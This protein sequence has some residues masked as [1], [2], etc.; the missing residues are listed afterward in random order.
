MLAGFPIISEIMASNDVTLM[1]EDGDS[2]DWIE[3]FNASDQPVDLDNWHL[4]DDVDRLDKWSFPSVVL[5]PGDFLLVFASGK[6][7]M[8]F[9]SAI[10]FSLEDTLAIAW[11]R[12]C[13]RKR[14]RHTKSTRSNG[15][16]TE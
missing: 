2:S 8:I 1:D 14:V 15:H 7:T 4:T 9:S 12:L 16:T 5:D 11:Y 6:D 10:R 3:I 13:S